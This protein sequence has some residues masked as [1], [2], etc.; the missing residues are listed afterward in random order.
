MATAVDPIPVAIGDTLTGTG[1]LA[2]CTDV[3]APT[4]PLPPLTIDI[5]DMVPVFDTVAV[6][7]AGT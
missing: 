6:N 5:A 7:S 1:G 4:Y 2:I 3:V